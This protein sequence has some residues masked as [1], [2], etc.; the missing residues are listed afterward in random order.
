MPGDVSRAATAIAAHGPADADGADV[1]AEA[2]PPWPSAAT[3]EAALRARRADVGAM[4][5]VEVVDSID[6][7]NTALLD[8]PFAVPPSAA[9]GAPA[10]AVPPRPRLLAA[11]A[12][13]AGRGRRGRAW[14]DVDQ[15]LTFSVAFDRDVRGARPLHGL[16]IAV[17]V[18]LAQALAALGARVRVKWP[19]D[20]L[21]DGRKAAGILVETRRAADRERVVVGVGLN[22]FVSDATAAGRSP[23]PAGLFDRPRAPAEVLAACTDA[24]LDGWDRFEAQGLVPFAQAWPTWDAWH[25]ETVQVMEGERLL[26]AGTAQGIDEDGALRIACDG[27]VERVLVGDVSL[28]RAECAR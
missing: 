2:V 27:R 19:N 15:A 5:V 20:L 10:A 12:Q 16:S 11:R 4:P 23:P 28:R 17:G 24:L 25:G 21:R 13:T 22:L 18:T 26:L 6:S 1:R 7:T 3:V 9:P 8:A 14:L